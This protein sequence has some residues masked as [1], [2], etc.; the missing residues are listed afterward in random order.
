MP[1]RNPLGSPPPGMGEDASTE[2]TDS[3][4]AGLREELAPGPLA[5]SAVLE[6]LAS[7]SPVQLASVRAVFGEVDIS[8]VDPDEVIDLCDRVSERITFAQY[9]VR[10]RAR[11]R[12]TGPQ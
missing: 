7:L 9:Q 5:Q 2:V 6:R 1:R 12:S 10:R 11:R 8:Q 3:F 4:D